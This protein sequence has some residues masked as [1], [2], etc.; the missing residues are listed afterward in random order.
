MEAGE[1]GEA[2]EDEEN[3]TYAPCPMPHAPC[4][5]PTRPERSR[6]DAPCPL[7]LLG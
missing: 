6:R 1:A 5:M 2:G 3:I 4:P 7:W